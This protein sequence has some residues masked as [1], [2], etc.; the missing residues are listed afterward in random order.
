[1]NIVYIAFYLI[2]LAILLHFYQQTLTEFNHETI[3]KNLM[4]MINLF[5][6]YVLF[7]LYTKTRKIVYL[8]PI[9]LCIFNYLYYGHNSSSKE[10]SKEMWILMGGIA[11]G[12]FGANI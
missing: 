3:L 2:I 12:L 11:M 1:M 5:V 6:L 10:H 9:A 7:Y 8:I 4:L